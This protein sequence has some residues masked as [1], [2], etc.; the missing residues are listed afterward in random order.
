[1]KSFN[2]F[3]ILV[4]ACC[5][6]SGQTNYPIDTAALSQYLQVLHQNKGFSGEVLVAENEQILFQGTVGL[7]NV[8]YELPITKGAKYHIASITKTF[9]ATL[10]A[11]AQEADK[12]NIHDNAAQYLPGLSPKFNDITIEQLVRHTSGLPHNEAIEDYWLVKSKLPMTTAQ[13]LEEINALDLL[14]APGTKFHYSSPGYFLLATILE[15]IY[16]KPYAALLKEQLLHPLQMNATGSVNTLQIIPRMTS[17]Y[18]WMTDDSLVVAPYRNYSMLKGAGDLYSTATD[19]LKWNNAFLSG[20][21]PNPVLMDTLR[22]TNSKDAIYYGFGWYVSDEKPRKLYHGGGTWGYSTYTAFYPESGISIILLSNA[23]TLPMT[24]IGRDVEQIVFGKPF[25]MPTVKR[26]I[27]TDSTT[28]ERY[29][30][31]FVSDSKR[32]TLTITHSG[33]RLYAQL[34][35]NPPFQIHPGG[36]HRFFGRKADV[37]F[38]FELEDNQIMGL[39]AQRQGQTIHFNKTDR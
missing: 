9:T 27:S 35:G 15:N 30:G 14:A 26:A 39:T 10:I 21:L 18:H 25:L 37:K 28:L 31:K 1:M 36:R 29:T 4:I 12:L 2:L 16:E 13:V 20:Q 32:M 17:G 23:S 22:K 5:I 8:E 24:T 3:L 38:T 19:L 7:A 6:A 11:M 33:K 34:A